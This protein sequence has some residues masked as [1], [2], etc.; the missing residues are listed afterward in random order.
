MSPISSFISILLLSLL[1]CSFAEDC[2]NIYYIQN[3]E[4]GQLCLNSTLVPFV[5][6]VA[7]VGE[8]TCSSVGYTVFERTEV[9]EGQSMQ[10]YTKPTLLGEADCALYYYLQDDL[11]TQLCLDSTY[12]PL[13]VN[14]TGAGQGTCDSLGYNVLVRN[15]SMAGQI[16][17]VYK[18]PTTLGESD[19]KILSYFL[20]DECAQL[21]MN[22][23]LVPLVI[24]IP[25]VSQQTCA[26]LG[27]TVLD[28]TETLEGQTMDIYKKPTINLLAADPCVTLYK[29]TG[30]ECGQLCVPSNEVSLLVQFGGV[31]QGTCGAQGYT[32]FEK[33]QNISAGP[34]GSIKVDVYVKPTINLLSADPCV[35]LYKVTGSE[36]GQLCVPSSEV[37]LLVQFGGVTQGSCGA[38]GYTVY[39][40][41]QNISAGPFGSIKVD[42]Y[43]KPTI[44]LL[45]ADPCVTL[46][47]ITGS[48]CGQL[49]VSSDKVPY[50]VEFGGVTQGTCD[51]QGYS[52]F[53]KSQNIDAGPFGSI[54]VDVY[55]KPKPTSF[56]Q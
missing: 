56:L 35:T 51:S 49:C 28:R 41:T 25:G 5:I 30:T 7:G 15:D 54:K 2:Q 3:T 9:V 55:L 23:T 26:S 6:K 20:N 1:V 37:S 8:G 38:Q 16:M 45:S 29:I 10:I 13:V 33:T 21:C 47:K 12:V 52:V 27:F 42:V 22:S 19:C 48:E 18:K 14:L 39:E 11:C 36:C 43:V 44:N 40:K 31:T 4:C 32:V 24:V 50:L 34:F 53:E 17:V 46:Y